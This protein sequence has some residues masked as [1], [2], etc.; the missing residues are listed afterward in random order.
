[1]DCE[2]LKSVCEVSGLIDSQRH[3]DCFGG[4]VDETHAAV[5]GS[6]RGVRGRRFMSVK[7]SQREV[8]ADFKSRKID[9]L[10][11]SFNGLRGAI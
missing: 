11:V 1:M 5:C 7:E 8:S 4:L 10:A 9:M 3:A 6:M 2:P